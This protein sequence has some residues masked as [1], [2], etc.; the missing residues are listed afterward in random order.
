[1]PFPLGGGREPIEIQ[2][3]TWNNGANTVSSMTPH[4]NDF[5]NANQNQDFEQQ[6]TAV[7]GNSY[8]W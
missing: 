4:R 2:S 1:L 5:Q 6:F 3:I 8:E 7:F